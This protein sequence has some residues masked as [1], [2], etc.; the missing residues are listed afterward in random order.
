LEFLARAI[1]GEQEIKGMQI[2]KEEV[3]VSLFAVDMILYLKDPKNSTKKKPI[4]NYKLFW[5]SRIQN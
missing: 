4:R 3:K 2:G 1:R 5:Q